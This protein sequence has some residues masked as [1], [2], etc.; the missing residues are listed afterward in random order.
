MFLI[1]AT[2]AGET[3]EVDAEYPDFFSAVAAAAPFF[4]YGYDVAI[5]D[6]GPGTA[7]H[8]SH[9]ANV[10]LI[11]HD[12]VGNADKLTKTGHRVGDDWTVFTDDLNTLSRKC[13]ATEIRFLEALLQLE[14]R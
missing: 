14:T 2:F 4:A 1:T 10:T 13:T 6:K 12:G 5:I 9:A 7:T 3:S 8:V 11:S